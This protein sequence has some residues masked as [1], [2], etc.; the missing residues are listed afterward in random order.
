M[1]RSFPEVLDYVQID[2]RVITWVSSSRYG[3]K[4]FISH[5]REES[6]KTAKQVIRKQSS[7]EK[8]D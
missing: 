7:T 2:S 4:N 3:N 8:N 6:P 5:E 1:V